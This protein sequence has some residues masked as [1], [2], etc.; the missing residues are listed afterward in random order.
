M[1]KEAMADPAN[2]E[3]FAREARAAVRLQGPH[4]A[5]VLDVGKLKNGEPYMVMEYLDGKDL[6][7]VVRAHG[8]SP[9]AANAAFAAYDANEQSADAAK[10]LW[11]GFGVGGAL[12]IAGGIVLFATAPSAAS[13]AA[14]PSA[15]VH[16]HVLPKVGV[17]DQGL[18]VI[19]TL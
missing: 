3:R 8:P 13:D 11:I 18:S 10:P 7:E 14:P 4:T 9:E 6:D 5:R 12:L 1:L 2:A 16:V 17:H 15:A 19:G